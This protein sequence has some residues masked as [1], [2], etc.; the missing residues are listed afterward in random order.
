M[1]H[2][3]S[4]PEKAFYSLNGHMTS[5]YIEMRTDDGQVGKSYISHAALGLDC[6]TQKKHSSL[7]EVR[8]GVYN[9]R[10]AD[11]MEAATCKWSELCPS[12]CTI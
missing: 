8:T 11:L 1:K 5:S 6:A 7:D 10:Y 4:R 2:S 3:K 12:Q 9:T